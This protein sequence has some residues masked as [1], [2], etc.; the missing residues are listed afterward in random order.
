MPA[1]PP[2]PPQGSAPG[3]RRRII[4]A[5]L[6]ALLGGGLWQLVG[7]AQQVAS[8]PTILLNPCNGEVITLRDTSHLLPH[9]AS[10]QSGSREA[11]VNAVGLSGVGSRGTYYLPMGTGKVVLTLN[12]DGIDLVAGGDL[13]LVARAGQSP[14]FRLHG[15]S[16]LKLSAAQGFGGSGLT[17]RSRCGP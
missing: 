12:R 6:V 15:I 9:V 3:R 11:S 5:A 14:D 2:A 1:A 17:L 7:V 13:D 8:A 16:H 10:G 4:A